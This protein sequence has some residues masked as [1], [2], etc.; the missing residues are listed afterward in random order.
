MDKA[1][2]TSSIRKYKVFV[3]RN[4]IHRNLRLLFLFVYFGI[5]RIYHFF[6]QDILPFKSLSLG[7]T[8]W[9]KP[10][11]TVVFLNERKEN[12]CKPSVLKCSWIKGRTIVPHASK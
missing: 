10:R 3:Q 5:H 4:Q 1:E 7:S 11:I 9:S 6:T 12:W 8:N 2:I